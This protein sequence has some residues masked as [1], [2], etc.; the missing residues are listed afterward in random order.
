ML[1]VRKGDR[2]L[3]R[4]LQAQISELWF[5]QR[6][7]RIRP[8][9]Y[10]DQHQRGIEYQAAEVNQNNAQQLWQ[11]KRQLITGAQRDAMTLLSDS[12][13]GC[14]RRQRFHWQTGNSQAELEWAPHSQLLVS[15]RLQHG[16]EFWQYQL[17][18]HQHDRVAV[19]NELSQLQQYP[20][21][22]YADVGDMENDPF[23]AQMINQGFLQHGASGFYNAQGESLGAQH[24]D[25]DHDHA[26]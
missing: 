17:K 10:F 15:Y 7:G 21:V 11:E 18:S 9:R 5:Q 1:L 2:V 3:Q 20:T 24:K 12:G 26:H 6:N 19:D 8:T 13:Q 4:F 22:D 16:S 14:N 25:H 23:L